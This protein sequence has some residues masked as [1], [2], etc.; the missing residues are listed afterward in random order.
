M[1]DSLKLHVRKITKL[2]TLPVI[3]REILAIIDDDLTP[4]N[5]LEKIIENDPPISAKILS[6]A[7]S[8]FFG[9]RMPAKTLNN[10]IIRI[11]F[12][13]VKNIAIGISLI[14]VL[15]EGKRG[16]ALDYQR[17]FNHSVSVGF[18]ASLLSEHL[19]LAI[20]EGIL[21]NGMLHDI[22]FLVLSRYF[23]ETYLNV[24]NEF[25]KGKPL[26]EAEKE[27]LDFTHA[28]IGTWLAEQWKLPETVLNTT[29][30]HHT[31]SLAKDDL[32]HLAVVHI[33]DYISTRSILSVTGK[34]PGYPFDSSCLEILGMS[35][36]DFADIETQVKNGSFLS[37]IF[38]L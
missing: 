36:S 26:I 5:K 30:Y 18:I 16:G 7:N 13:N 34:N 1:N 12:N 28:D 37:G 27:V 14:T 19:K 38:K 6:V 4:V 11:G 2:P 29:L 25:D 21:I 23:S 15:E 3:A 31:P 24:L 10:A 9:F 32:Q 8:A 17:V 20:P 33:A 22:G 35:D